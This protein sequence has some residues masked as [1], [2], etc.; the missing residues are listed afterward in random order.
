MYFT[1][2][3][4]PPEIYAED[5]VITAGDSF[6]PFEGVTAHDAEDGDITDRVRIAEY[7]VNIMEAGTYSITYEVIDRGGLSAT[8][9]ITVTVLP[10]EDTGDDECECEVDDPSDRDDAS[11]DAGRDEGEAEYQDGAEDRDDSDRKEEDENK[12]PQT[13]T[14]MYNYLALGLVLIVLAGAMLFIR[15]RYAK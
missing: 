12:L 1:T 10:Q 11:E 5:I 2:V 8:T 15:K 13:A 14:N 6:N 7:N 9:T 3:N 4:T